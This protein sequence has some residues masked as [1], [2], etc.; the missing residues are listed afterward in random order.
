MT[1]STTARRSAVL[2]VLLACALVGALFA[3]AVVTAGDNATTFQFDPLEVDAEAGETVTLDLVVST[4]GGYGGEGADELS[5][6]L[7]YDSD[8]VTVTEVEHGPMLAAGNDSDA[9]VDGS[10]NI[11]DERGTVTIEQVREP[12]GDG[13]V[14]TDTAATITL[15]IADDAPST[16]TLEITDAEAILVTGHP[17]ASLERDA[18]IAV[19]GG[20][21][22]D[23]TVPGFTP[24][25]AVAAIVA[26]IVFYSRQ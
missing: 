6:D 5:I 23:D 2:A 14:G 10:V 3:P 15:E 13:A 24:L 25:L 21:D 9:E 16:T 1:G 8:A 26:A 4:H 7:E 19:D 17:Q 20:G 22:G 11:D 12:S 18:T